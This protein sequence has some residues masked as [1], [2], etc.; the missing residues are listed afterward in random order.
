[1]RSSVH[2]ISQARIVPSAGD[3]P[4]PGTEPVSSAL[5][6]GFFNAEPP[7]KLYHL[8]GEIYIC[9]YLNSLVVFPTFFNLSLNFAISS[10]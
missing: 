6:S 1:M 8:F 7:V 10:S 9:K 3:L 4:N 2:G 5:A